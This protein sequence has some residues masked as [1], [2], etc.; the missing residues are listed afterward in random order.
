MSNLK[1]PSI[2]IAFTE[3]GASAIE[4]GERGI[5]AL[6]LKDS[7]VSKFR[8]YDITDIP[9]T[10]TAANIQYIK[11]ALVGYTQ[12]PKYATVY[13]MPTS[14]EIATAYSD[15][16]KYFETENFNYFACPTAETDSKASDLAAWIKDQRTNAYRKVKAVLPNTDAADNDGVINWASILYHGTTE[17][18]VEQGTP[19]IAGLLAGTGLTLSATYAP[20][21]DFTDVIRLTSDE[22]DTAVSSGKLIAFWDGEKVKLNRAVTSFVTTTADKLDSFKKIK[23]VEDM[24]MMYTDIRKTIEDNYIGKFV[25]SYDNKCLLITAVNA[26]FQTLINDG[27]LSAGTCV[28]DV[29]AQR[30]WLT[31]QGKPIVLDDGTEVAIADATD[32]QIKQA[33]T[34]SRVFLK[35][36]VSIL[37]AIEDV[38][39]EINI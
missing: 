32:D 28:I 1:S 31:A 29:T 24:D 3:K 35:A 14:G 16:L 34:G 38:D 17:V 26:Y 12:S 19:R 22:Q 5:V 37:D 36:T 15:M 21:K 9:T 23:I 4:R 8:V 10:L 6:A 30:T 11:D 7:A 25:N 18:T 13:V 27:V 2:T 20:L 33:N 39:L